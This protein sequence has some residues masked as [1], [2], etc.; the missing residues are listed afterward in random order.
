M[1]RITLQALKFP[2][3]TLV[4]VIVIGAILLNNL[5]SAL[6]TA[7]RELAR[8]QGNVRD[9]SAR[10]QKARDDN[11][12]IE[13]Y[14]DNYLYLQQIGVVGDE[15]RLNWLDSLRFTNQQT[16][17][18][19]YNYQIGTQQAYPYAGE[20]DPGPLTLHQSVMKIAIRLLHEGDLISFLGT[21]AQQR[22]G[23]FSVDQCT[24]E[25][26]EA[27]GSARNRPNVLADCELAWITLRPPAAAG[28]PKT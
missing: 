28:G 25:R 23:V 20:L 2:L 26:I 4:T 10:L 17:V 16:R 12:I 9:A 24:M 22:A 14:L 18:F 8:Q 19:G 1:N 11:A 6:T 21:L 13:R 3:V 27:P 7:K 5:D 15:Q